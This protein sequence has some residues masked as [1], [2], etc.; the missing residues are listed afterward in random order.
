[1]E[2]LAAPV[3]TRDEAMTAADLLTLLEYLRDRNRPLHKLPLYLEVSIS[4]CNGYVNSD[5][6]G[7]VDFTEGQVLM[8]SENR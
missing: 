6:V 3:T 1:M 5:G 7:V 8:I 2:G 4:D